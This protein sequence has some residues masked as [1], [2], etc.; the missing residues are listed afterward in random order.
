[1]ID[2]HSH[3]DESDGS[4]KPREL[5][6]LATEVGLEALAI[7]DH[8]TFSGYHAAL[9]FAK[10]EGLDLVRAI[11]LN[12]R[13]EVNGA[14][15][16]HSAHILAY[17]PLSEPSQEFLLWLNEARRE[18][19][20]RNQKLIASLQAA[21]VDITLAEVEARGRTLTSR[22]HF[23]R[24]LV[25]KGYASSL[26]DAFNR[27]LGEDA[28]SYVH[29]DSLTTVDTVSL[30]RKAG[31]IA[32]VAHPIRLGLPRVPERKFLADAKA[33]GLLG[34]EV[35][36]SE[37]SP[38]LQQYYLQLARELDLL[39]TGGSDFHGPSVKPDIDLGTGRRGNVHVP[40]SF[41]TGL[42]EAAA[43]LPG[44]Q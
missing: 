30:V 10:A 32:S 35:Y 36:H 12:S 23:A 37:H 39:P 44:V 13:V 42:R 27:Y 18:R 17:F 19:N 31:G 9:P 6:Q 28:A 7:T 33:A 43:K 24:V 34:L 1:L 22:P 8:D 41:L 20:E 25:D 14:S 2:L 21:G 5:I 4:L 26:E 15:T 40:L 16:S 11:E 3:T 29:R 38:E